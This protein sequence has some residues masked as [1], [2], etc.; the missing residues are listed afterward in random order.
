MFLCTSQDQTGHKGGAADY[1]LWVL[2][3][4]SNF[5]VFPSTPK[6]LSEN[7]KNL[8]ELNPLYEDIFPHC[9]IDQGTEVTI[10]SVKPGEKRALMVP[11]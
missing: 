2:E 9:S 11:G 6:I 7:A 5:L 1:L 4:I 8:R 3:R 10:I